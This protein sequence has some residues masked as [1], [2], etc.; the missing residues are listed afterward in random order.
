MSKQKKKIS[1]FEIPVCELKIAKF[2]KKEV[3]SDER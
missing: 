3:S 1:K 2:E